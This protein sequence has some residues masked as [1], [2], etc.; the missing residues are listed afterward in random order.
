VGE[1]QGAHIGLLHEVL[2]LRPV[3]RQVDGEVV[4]SVEML[5]RL[6]AEVLVRSK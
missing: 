6:P 2:G 1:A 3:A 5:E 4:E